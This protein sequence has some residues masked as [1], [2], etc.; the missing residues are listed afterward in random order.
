M[1]PKAALWLA[2][3]DS[4]FVN[5]HALVV[6]GGL[7]GGMKWSDSVKL[8]TDLAVAMGLPVG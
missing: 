6:D 2:S 3:E 5:G 7:T 8:T 1:L 4:C